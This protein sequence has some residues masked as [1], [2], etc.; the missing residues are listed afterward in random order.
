MKNIQIKYYLYLKDR[1][2]DSS[3]NFGSLMDSCMGLHCLYGCLLRL[4]KYFSSYA[5]ELALPAL[6]LHH[7]NFYVRYR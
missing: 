5:Y 1:L 6:I 7:H 4:I 2:N 3:L